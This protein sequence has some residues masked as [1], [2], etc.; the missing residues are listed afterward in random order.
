M[1]RKI[2]TE[3]RALYGAGYKIRRII[4]RRKW[5]LSEAAKRLSKFTDR[6]IT[7]FNLSAI[8]RDYCGIRF[9]YFDA[10]HKVFGIDLHKMAQSK[11]GSSIIEETAPKVK[12]DRAVVAAYSP[13][14]LMNA[15]YFRAVGELSEKH[16]IP[17]ET[18]MKSQPIGSWTRKRRLLQTTRPQGTSRR[19]GSGYP[20]FG[21]DKKDSGDSAPVVV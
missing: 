1:T 21:Q 12:R 13:K 2:S 18:L 4:K 5:T 10:F 6:T 20:L 14:D 7:P 9:R 17:V 16:G 3:R 8:Q 15:A 19:R 11:K